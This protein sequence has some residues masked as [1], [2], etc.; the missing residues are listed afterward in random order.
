MKQMFIGGRWLAAHAGCTL[1]VVA[2]ADAAAFDPIPRA[3]AHEVDL[4]VAAARA[5]LDG[6]WGRL[7]ATERGRLLVRIGQAV[8]DHAEEPAQTEACDTGKP[9]TTARG[10]DRE[11]RPPAA[12]G[13]EVKAGQVFMNCYGASG[14]VALPFGATKR[15]GHGR[16]KGLLAQAEVSPTKTLV[17]YP[18]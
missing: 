2:P 3:S 16:E 11:R 15:S 7:N 4:A 6:P 5:A 10:V 17:D 9:I 13:Q 14:G 12:R 18:G 8:Q 1:A